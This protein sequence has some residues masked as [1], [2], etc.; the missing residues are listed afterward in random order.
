M[1]P[2]GRVARLQIQ[3]A[4]LKLGARPARRYEP[5]PLQEVPELELGPEGVWGHS[6]GG[7]RI[8]DVHNRAHEAHNHRGENGVCFGFT[9]HY[10]ALRERFGARLADGIAGE[11]I[12]IESGEAPELARV[13][14][15][16]GIERD[17]GALLRLTRVLVAEPC[18]EFAR[19]ALGLPLDAPGGRHVTEAL[20]ALREGRR[21]FYATCAEPGRI[22]VGATV[23]VL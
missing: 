5:A 7:E 9:R 6:P 17:G 1:S 23:Y 3:R 14:G 16:L 15:G 4:R 18:L 22:R 11:N 10:A 13:A 21:G 19:Y 8:A 20:Q 12:L 2:L